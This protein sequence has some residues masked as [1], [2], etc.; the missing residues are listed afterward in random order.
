[1]K[2]TLYP[3]RNCSVIFVNLKRELRKVLWVFIVYQHVVE[4]QGNK[5]IKSVMFIIYFLISINPHNFELYFSNH[6]IYKL[7]L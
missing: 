4:N 2:Y 6:Y 5:N 3:I 1:M 7:Y